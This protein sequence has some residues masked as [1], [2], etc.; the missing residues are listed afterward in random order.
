M[1]LSEG[2]VLTLT[3]EEKRRIEE[4]ARELGVSMTY[5]VVERALEGT[6]LPTP[7]K[8]PPRHSPKPPKQ[9]SS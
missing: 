2:L 7:R 3:K 4:K 8:R 1:E 9:H 5:Y 6:E